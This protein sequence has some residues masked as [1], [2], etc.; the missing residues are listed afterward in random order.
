MMSSDSQIK[1][2]K[3]KKK[4]RLNIKKNKFKNDDEYVKQRKPNL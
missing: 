1:E 2:S 4:L 3:N